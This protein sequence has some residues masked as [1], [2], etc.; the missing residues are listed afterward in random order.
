M[1]EQKKVLLQNSKNSRDTLLSMSDRGGD[2]PLTTQ[3]CCPLDCWMIIK[4]SRVILCPHPKIH[5]QMSLVKYRALVWFILRISQAERLSVTTYESQKKTPTRSALLNQLSPLLCMWERSSRWMP[6]FTFPGV[7]WKM[8]DTDEWLWGH[9]CCSHEYGIT[10]SKDRWLGVHDSG[11]GSLTPRL[12]SDKQLQH[13][14]CALNCGG[15][16]IPHFSC[17]WGWLEWHRRTSFQISG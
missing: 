7:Q 3:P 10:A 12:T 4:T 16:L 2:S 13:E 15:E 1:L 8:H 14:D 9:F 17:W 5:P 11:F 6:L